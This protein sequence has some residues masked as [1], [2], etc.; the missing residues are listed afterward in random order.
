M[1]ISDD[2][3]SLKGFMLGTM[4]G[5]AIGLPYEGISRRR[6]AALLDS[7]P[8]RHRLLFRYGLV[9]DDTEHMLMTVAAWRRSNGDLRVFTRHLALR[10]RLWMLAIPPAT[11]LATARACLKLLV[12]IPPHRSGVS[13]AG[14]GP[15]MRSGVLGI[16]CRTE[17]ELCEYVRAATRITHTDER[18]EHGALSI[19]LA[20]RATRTA[21]DHSAIVSEFTGSIARLLP[22]GE[23]RC[24]IDRVCE[25]VEHG[26]TTEQYADSIGCSRGVTG[27]VMHTAPVVLHL[28]M[29]NPANYREGVR[30]MV[31][32]GGDTDTTAAILGGLLGARFSEAGLP[33]DWLIGIKDFP[34][35]R[36]F[37]VRTAD[38]VNAGETTVRRWWSPRW[39]AQIPRN[40]IFFI[41][42]LV[43]ACRRLAPPYG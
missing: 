29:S 15:L 3:N 16:V 12:G 5:D 40:L 33:Q 8:L 43:H 23:V 34:V 30:R 6:L 38:A 2:R 7:K 24:A 1:Q 19:A 4:I 35:T 36:A 21:L 27:Y 11:G 25:S 26:E 37:V 18:A 9:S 31:C 28:W 42:V 17:E 39:A 22:S 20:A 32:L 10:L 14:N 41:I 13:S